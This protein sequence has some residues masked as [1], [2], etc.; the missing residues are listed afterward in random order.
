MVEDARKAQD[1]K[2]RIELYQKASQLIWEDAPWV[3]LYV[4]KYTVVHRKNVKG[5][6]VNSVEKFNAIYARVD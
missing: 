6:V 3:F 2:K 5:I 4:Q 1:P